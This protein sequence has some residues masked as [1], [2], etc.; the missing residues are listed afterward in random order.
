[1]ARI[2]VRRFSIAKTAIS[3]YKT[4]CTKQVTLHPDYDSTV[5]ARR[6]I[7]AVGGVTQYLLARET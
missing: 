1:M 4:T 6:G 5:S 7:V 2:V 3:G